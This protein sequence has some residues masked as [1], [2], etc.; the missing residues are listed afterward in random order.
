VPQLAI[1]A[2]VNIFPIA[3]GIDCTSAKRGAAFNPCMLV[4]VARDASI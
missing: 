4:A 2:S 3:I 1:A